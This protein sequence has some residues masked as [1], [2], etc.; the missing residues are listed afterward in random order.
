MTIQFDIN[1]ATSYCGSIISSGASFNTFCDRHATERNTYFAELEKDQIVTYTPF[2]SLFSAAAKEELA[3]FKQ[4]LEASS[5]SEEVKEP[6][7]Q[8]IAECEKVMDCFRKQVVKLLQNKPSAWTSKTKDFTFAKVA[9]LDECNCVDSVSRGNR[10]SFTEELVYEVSKSFPK[11]SL[12]VT[13]IGVGKGFHEL[14]IHAAFKQRDYNADWD[15]V[16]SSEISAETLQSF[17]LIGKWVNPETQVA[18]IHET[19]QKYFENLQTKTKKP[20]VFLF[21]DCNFLN[22]EKIANFGKQMQHPCLFGVLGESG[23]DSD[24]PTFTRFN[25]NKA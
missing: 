17:E 23:N 1:K 16:D 12:F 3:V 6:L 18:F 5:E 15:L 21:I 8:K 22:A 2:K 4:S 10:Q 14:S 19:A 24:E 7:R 13:T 9:C 11:G 25:L 20:D